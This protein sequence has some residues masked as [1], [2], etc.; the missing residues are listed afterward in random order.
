MRRKEEIRVAREMFSRRAPSSNSRAK[1]DGFRAALARRRDTGVGDFFNYF[2]S[3]TRWHSRVA[4][5]GCM[6]RGGRRRPSY[7]DLF[8]APAARVELRVLPQ[9]LT[10][11]LCY[12]FMLITNII[13]YLIILQLF[14]FFVCHWTKFEVTYHLRRC[15]VYRVSMS[16]LKQ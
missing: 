14:C 4:F 6:S 7:D 1:S 11:A 16:L 13:L 9:P 3:S 15:F 2:G 10:R 12:V 5:Q 8:I